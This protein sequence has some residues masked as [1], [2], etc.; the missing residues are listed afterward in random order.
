MRTDEQEGKRIMEIQGNRTVA[1]SQP[2]T[3]RNFFRMMGG[4]SAVA[5]GLAL[6]SA[7]KDDD[8][9][10]SEAVVTPTPTSSPTSGALPPPYTAND[11]DRL[12]F[13]L[14]LHYL[15]SAYLHRG[16][17]GNT[18]TAGLTTGAGTVGSVSGGRQVMFADRMMLSMMQEVM[19]ATDGRI[20]YLRRTLGAAVTAQPAINIAGGQGSPFQ[21]I[22][23]SVRGTPTAPT[24]FFDPYASENDFLL[25]ATALFAVVS[26]ATYDL[27]W[28]VAANLTA[29]MSAMA[30]GLASSDAIVRNSLF[31]RADQD[32]RNPAAGETNLFNRAN[33][34][35]GGRDQYDGPREMDQGI[36]GFANA[37]WVSAN[38][39]VV[40][41]NDI[42]MR[43]TPEQALGILYASAASAS[44]GA[45]FPAGV[46]GTIRISGANTF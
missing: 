43:R 7:C 23:R 39:D 34:M 37:D 46:N 44:S 2:G 11:N 40:G 12:N 18:L 15:L 38:V 32:T 8:V 17:A 21:A 42:L 31:I 28:Y 9:V 14:Q 45:F 16:I 1:E 5:S 3:R 26:Q 20:A 29:G 35:A 36:G 13:A 25:G 4:V 6:L 27:T 22:A 30:N 19:T 41:G 24:T 33:D 10:G